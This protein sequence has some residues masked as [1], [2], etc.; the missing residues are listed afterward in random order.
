LLAHAGLA[1]T[2]I[3]LSACLLATVYHFRTR[4]DT[5]Y[6]VRS[7]K[8]EKNRK[9]V[10]FRTSY[11]VL[12]TYLVP[13]VW[14]AALILAKASGPVFGCLCLVVVELERLFRDGAFS[15]SPGETRRDRLRRWMARLRPSLVDL[16][17]IIGIG[18][19]L[20]LL[21]CPEAHRI[22][23]YQARRNTGYPRAT[24]A[25]LLGRWYANNIWYYFPVAL[26][27]KL[28]LPLLFAPVL[29]AVTRPRS[30]T[31]WA[32]LAAAALVVFSLACRVQIGVRLVLPLVGLAIAGLAGAMAQAWQSYQPGWGRRLLGGAA[33]AGVVWTALAALTVWPRG[34]CYANELWGG[35]ARAY[36]YV[37][38]SNYDWGQGLKELADWQRRHGLATLDVWAVGP[39]MSFRTMPMRPMSMDALP[40]HEPADVVARVHGHYLAVSTTALYGFASNTPAGSFLRSLR[41]VDRTST[42]LIYDFTGAT[43]ADSGIHASAKR[44]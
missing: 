32:C 34:L 35:T 16:T 40:I 14:F 44:R 43:A 1:T 25:F 23:W 8:Y 41:P 12:R 17:L 22:F 29:L 11:L 39:Q 21:Y 2:D 42:F 38:D 5:K 19:A 9:Q 13:A 27:I 37:S 3:C 24:G 10:F 20:A 4:H 36:R 31:N 30:L 6:E 26:S 28:S 18:V 15:G 7:T 33:S